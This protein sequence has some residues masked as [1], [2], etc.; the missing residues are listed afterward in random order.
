MGKALVPLSPGCAIATFWEKSIFKKAAFLVCVNDPS[1]SDFVWKEWL[2]FKPPRQKQVPWLACN[3]QIAT[4][5][6]GWFCILGSLAT[7]IKGKSGCVPYLKLLRD[8]QAEIGNT[9]I[10]CSAYGRYHIDCAERIGKA[11]GEATNCI[12]A[13]R[14]LGGM[15][16]WR[17]HG[18]HQQVA[19]WKIRPIWCYIPGKISI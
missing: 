4:G 3:L 8:F 19:G 17:E 10:L 18:I 2:T 13:S 11:G 15:W 7:I 12:Q 5:F 6:V 9:Q 16:V 14:P 1:G